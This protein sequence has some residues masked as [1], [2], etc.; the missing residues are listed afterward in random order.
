MRKLNVEAARL[1]GWVKS[2]AE[3]AE[4]TGIKNAAE[5]FGTNFKLKSIPLLTAPGQ[6]KISA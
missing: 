6:E 1:N 4:E 3:A 2:P 5:L